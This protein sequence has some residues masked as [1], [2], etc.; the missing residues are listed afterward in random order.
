M[1]KRLIFYLP[2]FKTNSS[3]VTCDNIFTNIEY[4]SLEEGLFYYAVSTLKYAKENFSE[5][6]YLKVKN[7]EIIDI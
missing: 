5:W 3:R 6:V 4:V 2:S 7:F 1:E